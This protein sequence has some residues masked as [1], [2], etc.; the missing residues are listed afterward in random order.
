MVLESLEKNMFFHSVTNPFTEGKGSGVAWYTIAS[1]RFYQAQAR[2]TYT[3]SARLS[4]CYSWGMPVS[5]SPWG[6]G[7]RYKERSRRNQG[8]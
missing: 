4:P 3:C 1:D 2:Y 7:V 6:N 5:G 8:E